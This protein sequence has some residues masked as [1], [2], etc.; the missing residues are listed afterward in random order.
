[1]AF[2]F[3]SY[4]PGPGDYLTKLFA[5]SLSQFPIETFPLV[6]TFFGS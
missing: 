4:Y 1:M 5:K 2:D 3:I 6:Y